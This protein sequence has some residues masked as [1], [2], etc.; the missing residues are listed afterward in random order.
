MI[1]KEIITK[2]VSPKIAHQILSHQRLK[3]LQ[4]HL[5]QHLKHLCDK[6]FYLTV[7]KIIAFYKYQS[8][9]IQE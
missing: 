6:I 3:S 1:N 2:S 8:D 9:E 4:Y 5:L 7:F